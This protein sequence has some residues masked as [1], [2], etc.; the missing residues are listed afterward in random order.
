[1][2]IWNKLHVV[3]RRYGIR[4]G[5]LNEHGHHIKFII[6]KQ[7]F[8]LIRSASTTNATKLLCLYGNADSHGVFTECVVLQIFFEF[9][10]GTI[11]K[12]RKSSVI[13]D[14]WGPLG[15]HQFRI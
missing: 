5:M 2:Y 13:S 7:R 3:V 10:C 14:V 6:D 9:D 11:P 15:S 1:M 8:I 12:E 4:L